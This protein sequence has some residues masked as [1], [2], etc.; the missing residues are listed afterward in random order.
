MNE[1]TSICS[2][3]DKAL[4][5]KRSGF[6]MK[7]GMDDLP[8]MTIVFSPDAYS[9]FCRETSIYINAGGIPWN[10]YHGATIGI[11]GQAEPFRVV[12]R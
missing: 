7:H 4:W 9:D 5:A 6:Q 1:T 12:E 11:L 2:Q 8:L 10:T 3:I